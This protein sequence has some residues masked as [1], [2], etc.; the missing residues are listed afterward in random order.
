MP[1]DI[2]LNTEAPRVRVL[3]SKTVELVCALQLLADI[4]HHQ[5]AMEWAKPIYQ[6]MSDKRLAFLRK[7]ANLQMQGL[8]LLEFV[9][10]ERIFDDVEQFINQLSAYEND[11][12][13]YKITGEELSF[14][15]IKKI[16]A[17][18]NHLSVIKEEK[19]W[20]AGSLDTIKDIVSNTAEFQNDLTEILKEIASPEFRDKITET[21]KDYH[22]EIELLNQRLMKN[23]P[24]D[25][26]QEILGKKFRRVYDFR[27]YFFIPSFFI[28]PHNIRLFSKTAQLL[29]YD[30][31]NDLI[32][33]NEL[34]NKLS[35]NLK[36]ISDKTRLEILRLLISKANYGK[37][38][39]S[40]LN[41]T[42]AT[43][44][45]HLEQLK[46]VNLVKEDRE[47]NIKIFS[48]NIAEIDKLLENI[49]DYLYNK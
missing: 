19:P 42:T 3:S 29:V 43:I 24:L 44:S 31:R 8:E 34:G 10:E 26:A 32:A 21:A 23:E 5:F 6:R 41:L 7:I 22:Q 33:K 9:L 47:K 1:L 48:A 16:K 35:A 39:A 20:L 27:E 12:F 14:E 45:H 2:E 37:R 46:S 13:I 25:V 49:K 28:S 38:I 15:D 17:D 11:F 40:R 18:E 4:K 30:L 36:V